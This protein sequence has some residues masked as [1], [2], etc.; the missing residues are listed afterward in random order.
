[1]AL[2]SLQT[3]KLYGPSNNILPVVGHLVIKLE[4]KDE[5][6]I[7]P[8]FVIDSL[9]RPLLGLP[10]IEA[11]QL[12]ERV[13]ELEDPGE[14]FKNKFPKVFSGLGRIEEDAVPYALTTPRQVPIPLLARVKEELGRMEEIG[15]VSKIKSPTDWCAGMVVVPK[16]NGE[17]R[18]CVDMTKLNEALCRERHILPSVEQSLAQLDGSQVFTK[19]DARSG[20][21]KIPPSSESRALTTFITPFGRY[22]F[23]VLPFGIAS[24]LEHFQRRMSQ[25]LDGLSGVIAH[26]DDV[27]VCERD[28]AEHDVRLTAVLTRLQETD[29]TL[30]EK[31]TF[32]QSEVLFLGHKISAAGIEPDPEK[33]SAI[34]DMPTPQNVAEVRTFL[35]MATYVG[36]F[37]PQFSDTTKPLRDLLAKENDWS[38]GHMQQVA[39]DK[40][41]GD[42]A[43]QRVLAQYRP[44]AK[45]KVSADAS[46]FGLGAILTQMQDN[47]EWRPIAYISRSLSD[48][49]QRY[50]QVEKEALEALAIAF[51]RLSQYLIGRQFTAE[52]DHKP[53]LALLGKKALDDLPPR[54][55]RFRLRLLRFTYK[56]VYVPGKALITA[57]AL[58]RAPIKHPLS[59]EEQCLEG[60]VQVSI[61][62][63]RDSLPAS[64]T[65]LQQIAEEQQRDHIYQQ[66]CKK[67]WPRQ[68][69]L[70]QLLKPY[71]VHQSDFH[72]NGDL[73]MKGQRIVIPETL[74]PEMLDR[75]HDGHMGITKCR[76]RAQQSV[77]LSEYSDCQASGPV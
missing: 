3:K 13:S 39:F 12:I 61:N 54:V 24:G 34:T 38:W 42:L 25:L 4:S 49:E 71:W 44:H 76:L 18:I 27:L 28:R 72:C 32:A 48:T 60:E 77:A 69:E 14:V 22:C 67:G 47:M 35:G 37:L 15:A 68:E 74:Q 19:L 56:M 55:L 57:D 7:Q 64:Q 41:K 70:P 16:A 62:A 45:T 20:F 66:I 17:I 9:A 52:T 36:K 5:S 75:V 31:C 73:L 2:C 50:A 26:A 65:K 23:N 53:L 43:S 10:A 51:E 30:N 59:E 63:I 1:M 40:I 8:V 6:A 58:S 21:W 29:L 46:S 33:I 11:L